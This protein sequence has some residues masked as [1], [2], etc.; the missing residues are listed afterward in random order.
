MS[1]DFRRQQR[2]PK[3]HLVGIS[4]VVILH[5]IVVY[6]LMSGLARQVVEVIR[7][8]IET[9]IVEEIKPPPPETPPPP[10]PKLSTPPPL[11]VPPPEVQIQQPVQ[12][13]TVSSVSNTRP[14]PRDFQRQ[15]PARTAPVIDAKHSC[16]MPEYPAASRRVGETGTVTLRFLIDVNGQAIQS[17]VESS[18][19]HRRLDQAALEALGRCKFK[20]GTVDGKPEQSW[21]KIKYVWKLQ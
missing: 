5:L 18:S 15:G 6:A 4:F 8:P 1:I 13:N 9:K 10:P 12:Q 17:G 14:P 16:K 11:Y 21:A 7:Q 19:G 20:P 2:N 3:N